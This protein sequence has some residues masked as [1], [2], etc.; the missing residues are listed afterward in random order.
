ME[1][2]WDFAGAKEKGVIPLSDSVVLKVRVVRDKTTGK[3]AFDVRSF[4]STKANPD[5]T[6][7]TKQGHVLTLEQWEQVL[8]IIKK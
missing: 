5:F 7:F 6:Q 2:R 4:V 1:Y 3:D 8:S